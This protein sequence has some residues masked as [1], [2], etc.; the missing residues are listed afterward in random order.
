MA[1]S[2]PMLM[3]AWGAFRGTLIERVSGCQS[4]VGAV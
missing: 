3:M 4:N 2:R 1:P